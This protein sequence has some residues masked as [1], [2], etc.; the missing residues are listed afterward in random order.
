MKQTPLF[1][2]AACLG[3]TVLHAQPTMQN[4]IFPD[5]NDVITIRFAIPTN[6][7]EGN[8]GANQNWNFTNL[9]NDPD[10]DPETTTYVLPSSTPYAA[11]FTNS[12]IAGQQGSGFSGAYAYYRKENTSLAVLGFATDSTLLKYTDTEIGLKVP[13]AYNGQ[14]E[15]TYAG[16][17]ESVT[18]FTFVRTGKNKATYDA[19][20]TLTTPLGTYQNA[21]RLKTIS[22]YKDSVSFGVGYTVI[23]TKI[24]NYSFYVANQPGPL[25]GVFYY[26]VENTTVFPGLPPFSEL[27]SYKEVVYTS[28]ITTPTNEAPD[29]ALA[30]RIESVTPNPAVDVL[31]VRFNADPAAELRFTVCDL[32]GKTLLTQTVSGAQAGSILEIP[33]TGLPAGLFTLNLTEGQAVRSVRFVKR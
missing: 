24:T 17:I 11:E 31:N 12:N 29:Q 14:F 2:F 4:N 33:V 21:M 23:E 25:V 27:D 32:T 5:I 28:S 26:D 13:L 3:F 1:L 9:Q 7:S 20:G 22:E 19:Y 15:D 30:L 10:L 18:G 8:A 6:V 16:S